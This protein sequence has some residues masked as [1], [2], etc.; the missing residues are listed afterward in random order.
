MK[1]TKVAE[2][3][4]NLTHF[5]LPEY[6]IT[7]IVLGLALLGLLFV[8]TIH[9]KT[10]IEGFF[11]LE[12]EIPERCPN[13]LIKKDKYFYLYNTIKEEVPGVNPIR[14]DSL[15]EYVSFTEWMK[16]KG[17]RCPVLYA[18]QMYDTQGQRTFKIIPDAANDQEG[19]RGSAANH[20]QRRLIDAGHNKGSMPGF[21]PEDQNIG[22][23]TPLDKMF[24]APN[25]KGSK[26]S[27]NPMDPNWGRIRASQSYA[28]EV[29]ADNSVSVA[30]AT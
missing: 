2:A 14:F 16:A 7:Y 21:D 11:G 13:L 15:E 20:I 24:N 1:F 5:E 9:S 26:A 30:V 25:G 27:W 3:I 28:D 10:A 22:V 19:G 4:N 6:Y 17:V 29:A 23:F 18:Q 8:S 12:T